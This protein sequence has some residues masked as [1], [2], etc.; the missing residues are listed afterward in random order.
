MAALIPS[1]V[2]LIKGA[3][4]HEMQSAPLTL[5]LAL[6]AIVFAVIQFFDSLHVKM[7]MRG[8]IDKEDQLVKKTETVTTSIENVSGRI[9][10]VTKSIQAVDLSLS[11]RFIGTFP[12]HFD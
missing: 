10:A 6:V 4:L 12:K 2:D 8:V 5:I 9:D 3:F 1:W 7:K 11:S